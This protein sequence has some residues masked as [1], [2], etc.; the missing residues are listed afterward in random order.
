MQ[1]HLYILKLR[2]HYITRHYQYHYLLQFQFHLVHPNSL[3]NHQD[4]LN[5]RNHLNRLLQNYSYMQMHLYNL[6]LRV[7]YITRH[8]Q[9]HCLLQFQFHLVHP[10]SLHMHQ[11]LL[12][13]RNRQHQLLQY[14]SCMQSHQYSQQPQLHHTHHRSLNRYLLMFLFHLVHLNTIHKHH[15]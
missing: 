7:H 8:Y 6:K 4:L 14:Y 15:Q 12:N 13:K 10:N 1:I 3:H 9:Y 11:D 2:V 5:K